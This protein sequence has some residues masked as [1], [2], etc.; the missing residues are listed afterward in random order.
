MR[1]KNLCKREEQQLLDQIDR[2]Q[3]LQKL[4][5]HTTLVENQHQYK[6]VTFCIYRDGHIEVADCF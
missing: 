4:S 5:C 3:T 2:V 1:Q 6:Y